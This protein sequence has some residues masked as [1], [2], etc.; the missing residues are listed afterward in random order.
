MAWLSRSG[1]LPTQQ[2]D[3]LVL[4]PPLL[5]Y[6]CHAVHQHSKRGVSVTDEQDTNCRHR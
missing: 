3:T 6:G 1:V 4:L 2:F 5:A